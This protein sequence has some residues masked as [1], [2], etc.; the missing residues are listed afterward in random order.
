MASLMGT[1][2]PDIYA[3]VGVHSGLPSGAARDMPSAFAAMKGGGMA[4]GGRL[5]PTIVFHG[6][7]DTT[8]NPVNGQRVIQIAAGAAASRPAAV[9][10][11]QVPHGHAYTRSRHV[12]AEGRVVAEKWLVHGAA[13]AWSGGHASGSYTD[14]RGPDASREMVRFFL[15]HPLAMHGVPHAAAPSAA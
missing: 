15:E 3:A 6:D 11:G 13:H 9:E 4:P 5:P 7:H 8:V 12:D 1:L 10:Q 2:Y 14:S